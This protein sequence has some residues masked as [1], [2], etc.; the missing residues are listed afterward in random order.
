MPT[1]YAIKFNSE[2]G[3]SIEKIELP[4]RV[5]EQKGKS[6]IAFPDDFTVIDIETTGLDPEVCEI[7]EIGAVRVRNGK[8]VEQF[9]SFVYPILSDDDFYDY[10]DDDK[11]I[12]LSLE[13]AV[14]N[15]I[16]PFIQRLTGITPDMLMEAPHVDEVLN[17]LTA[18]IGNDI[19]IGHNVN[20]DINF[21]YDALERFNNKTLEN[22][23]VDTLRLSRK[24]F[25]TLPH[26]TMK[27]L[28]TALDLQHASTHRTTGD[29]LAC[30][31][32][33]EKCKEVAVQE[34]IEQWIEKN[35]SNSSRRPALSVSEGNPENFDPESPLYGKTCVFT[36]TL[37]KM[38]RKEAMQMVVD[39]GG[40][41]ADNVTKS[42]DFLIMGE[43]DYS[44]FADGKE[45]SKTKK[46][47]SLQAKGQNIH[48]LSEDDFY[49][50]IFDLER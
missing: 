36:G 38:V 4:K 43:Q 15:Y 10:D 8:P 3:F 34:G 20:F 32:V 33:F 5:R 11:E 48:I 16:P 39:I 1:G 24:A 26:H 37:S 29:C 25:P 22:D 7:L 30:L 12:K 13:D 23:F 6:L 17:N 40:Q 47:K 18:F 27:Y 42:T 14:A 49:S 21:I 2:T 35:S 28:S 9:H 41:V 45:S 44:K 50:I 31:D 46:V 19:L